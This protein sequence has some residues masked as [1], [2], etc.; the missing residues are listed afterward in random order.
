MNRLPLCLVLA[1]SSTLLLAA[2]KPVPPEAVVILYNSA[3][4][5]SKILAKHYAAARKIPR[6]NLVGLPLPKTDE[7]SRLDYVAQL[8]D[9]LRRIFDE[10][11]WWQR[12]LCFTLL[13]GCGGD[14]GALICKLR[15]D[16]T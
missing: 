16:G 5:E 14:A 9:P 11:K 6:E 4:A 10:R 12:A 8:R 2:P 13:A 7:I 1:L 3:E 15:A